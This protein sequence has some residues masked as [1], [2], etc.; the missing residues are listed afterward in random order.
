MDTT[1][2]Q[3]KIEDGVGTLLLV[4]PEGKPPMLR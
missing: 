1:R 3:Y 2:I 4:A